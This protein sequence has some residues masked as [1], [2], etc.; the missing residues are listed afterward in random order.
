MKYILR[1]QAVGIT[2]DLSHF[3]CVE[4]NFCF[5]FPEVSPGSHLSKVQN[6]ISSSVLF[7]LV[8]TGVDGAVPERQEE[9]N[10]LTSLLIGTHPGRGWGEGFLSVWSV[11]PH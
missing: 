8:S 4:Q 7:L 10:V 3:D 5:C 11:L 2:Y 1:I 6:V 9:K